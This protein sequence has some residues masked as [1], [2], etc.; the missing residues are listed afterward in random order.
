MP[1]FSN[2]LTKVPRFNEIPVAVGTGHRVTQISDRMFFT[3]S[4]EFSFYLLQVTYGFLRIIPLS[5]L[6]LSSFY[7]NLIYYLFSNVYANIVGLEMFI[8][9]HFSRLVLFYQQLF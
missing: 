9:H 6:T 3:N 4:L 8:F 1:C 2:F 5:S 7:A